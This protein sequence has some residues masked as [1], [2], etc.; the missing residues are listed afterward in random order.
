ML[1]LPFHACHGRRILV[2]EKKAT[3]NLNFFKKDEVKEVSGVPKTMKPELMSSKEVGVQREESL[4]S[5]THKNNNKFKDPKTSLNKKKVS[6][7]NQ[8]KESLG[9]YTSWRVPHRKRG[10]H[11]PGFN[12]DYAPPKTHPPAHN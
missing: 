11:N 5:E 1:C 2:D 9:S 7:L 3:K 8:M 4:T 10:E 12:L 6:S